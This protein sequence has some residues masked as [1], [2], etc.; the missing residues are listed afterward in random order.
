ML[1]LFTRIVVQVHL[2]QTTAE[3]LHPASP[4]FFAEYEPVTGVKT[5]AATRGVDLLQEL[6]DGLRSLLKDIFQGQRH[7]ELLRLFYQ[8]GPHLKTP[9]KP[10]I[11]C[12]SVTP[13]FVFRMKNH[14]RGPG[15]SS[16]VKDV[17]Q[18]LLRSPSDL[19]VHPT[20]GQVH[21]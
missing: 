12:F 15:Q 2:D 16:K 10:E 11:E 7:A 21:E 14:D 9:L 13:L 5:K 18:S 8:G 19:A 6:F 17:L 4:A 1:V 20:G 3:Y